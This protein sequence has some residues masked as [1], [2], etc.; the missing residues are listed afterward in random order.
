VKKFKP[1]IKK[2]HFIGDIINYRGINDSL[3]LRTLI[4]YKIKNLKHPKFNCVYES[5]VLKIIDEVL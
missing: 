2:V 3:F 1:K 4:R 5:D